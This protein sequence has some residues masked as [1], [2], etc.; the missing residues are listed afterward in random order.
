ME[1]VTQNWQ[2]KSYKEF[3]VA[4]RDKK[5]E[6]NFMPKHYAWARS[7]IRNTSMLPRSNARLRKDVL[8]RMAFYEEFFLEA[9]RS[10][11]DLM[12]IK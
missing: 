2:P 8:E 11:I 1:F 3:R 5:I 12:L 10:D 6:L 9:R 4:V 7:R